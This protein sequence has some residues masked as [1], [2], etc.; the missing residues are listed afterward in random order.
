MNDFVT[1]EVD[2]NTVRQIYKFSNNEPG[3]CPTPGFTQR[4]T[5]DPDTDEIY[6]LSVKKKY[7]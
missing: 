4:A 7:K 5:L 3:I 6:V 2:T 1:Y